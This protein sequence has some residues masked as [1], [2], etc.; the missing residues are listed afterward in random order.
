MLFLAGCSE[1]FVRKQGEI[2][3]MAVSMWGA[4][5]WTQSGDIMGIAS[6]DRQ[7]VSQTVR[8]KETDRHAIDLGHITLMLIIHSVA[9]RLDGVLD[10]GYVVH[11]VKI[12]SI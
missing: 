2:L 8:Q 5:P 7:S 1:G 12:L 3:S 11:R 10:R 9:F 6:A 4:Q